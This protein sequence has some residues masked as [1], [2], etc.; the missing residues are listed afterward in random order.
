MYSPVPE[1]PLRLV[2]ESIKIDGFVNRDWRDCVV[3]MNSIFYKID[4]MQVGKWSMHQYRVTPA[5]EF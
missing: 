4:A 2:Y 3:L 1:K 5:W